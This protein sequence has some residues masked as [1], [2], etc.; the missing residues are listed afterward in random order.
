MHPRRQHLRRPPAPFH[1]P[2]QRCV[3][4]RRPP[5]RPGRRLLASA[6]A[7][8]L[9]AGMMTSTAY[10][11]DR[12]SAA[13][14]VRVTNP[15]RGAQQYV[16]DDWSRQVRAQAAQTPGD[17]GRR[18]ATVAGYPTAVWLDGVDAVTGGRGLVGHLDRA[19]AQQATAARPVV[20]Q[21]VL[22]N[23]PG[24]DCAEDGA[25][26]ELPGTPEG[27]ARYRTG[28]VDPI[29]EILRRR[30]YADLR[31]AVVVEPGALPTLF[32]ETRPGYDD[33]D[34]VAARDSG[35]Y[36]DGVR[37]ALSRL[38]TVR[39]AYPYLDLAHAGQLGWAENAGP[40]LDLYRQVVAAPA[41]PGVESV[42]GFVT[43]TANHVP[44]VEPFLPDP[45]LTVGG[46]PIFIS[47]FYDWN[48]VLDES[49]HVASL[50]QGL[51]QRG[52]PASI[53]M[54]VDTGRNGWGGPGRPT[55]ASTSTIVDR[56]VD[57]SRI[58]RRLA[59]YNWCNQTGTGLG[60]RPVADPAPG[61]HAYVWVKPPGESD[62]V[63][64]RTA[65]P[66]PDRPYLR[67]RGQCD[68]A[69]DWVGGSNRPTNALTGAPHHGHWFP[70]LFAQL[71]DNAHPP[72]PLPPPTLP[73]V[74]F[75]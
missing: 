9:A 60:E 36:V 19:L 43:N 67:H 38:K 32:T 57:E 30:A 33:P 51:V 56:F 49:D 45:N 54:L 17:L 58:D 20:A 22:Y 65:P 21:L 24:R 47:R 14:S 46:M 40:V 31:I 44:L 2:D 23:L 28:F 73:P 13:T 75:P 3:P 35:V 11:D 48:L 16:N 61:V 69:G 4:H 37:Y 53:G 68:P 34:C 50:R 70:Q 59:R 1:Q 66:D 10:A 41:G 27:L 62:G 8:V 64:Y 74:P 71:V 29:V 12:P 39:N 25:S 26:G 52:F 42:T 5:R 72:V 7:A 15:Y 18:M 63:T 6:T 55:R